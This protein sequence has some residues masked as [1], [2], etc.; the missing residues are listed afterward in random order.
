MTGR[1]C[2]TLALCQLTRRND[3]S[4]RASPGR[5]FSQRP[6]VTADRASCDQPVTSPLDRGDTVIGTVAGAVPSPPFSGETY[7]GRFNAELLD[8]TNVAA[9]CDVVERSVS[10]HRRM[11][12]VAGNAGYGV[13]AACG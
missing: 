5:R 11:D 13:V 3:L 4:A 9:I 2:L 7:P 8:V 6:R 10:R 1:R 12:V